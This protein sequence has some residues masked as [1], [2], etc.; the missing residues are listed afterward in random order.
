MTSVNIVKDRIAKLEVGEP[1]RVGGLSLVPI[2]GS[3]PAP[4]YFTASE[5]LSHG[6]LDIEELGDGTVPEILAVNNAV[7]PVLLLDG[8]HLE[9]AKQ[10]RIVN[11]SILLAANSTTR[12]PVSCV[13]QGRWAYR[14]GRKFASSDHH[15]YS[16]LRRIQA[17]SSLRHRK[18]GMAPRSDQGEVW[19]DVAFKHSEAAVGFS[20]AGAMRDAFDRQGSLLRKIEERMPRPAAGQVGILSCIGGRPVAADVFDQPATL[21]KLW[22]RL[23]RGYAMDAV[24]GAHEG[25][26]EV[27]LKAFLADAASAKAVSHQG[28]GIGEDIVLEKSG[29][30]GN[31]LVWSDHVLH[32]S[33]FRR[34]G[35]DAGPV[36]RRAENR[37]RPI[38]PQRRYF[39][40]S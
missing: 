5:A 24:G 36:D 30:L 15:S 21:A 13:E 40:T 27:D 29:V 7:L 35:G 4:D 37:E 9:G 28:V 23:I 33:L 8:E 26:E 31:G 11:L 1:N 20:E 32:I 6:F 14:G 34:E 10:S 17:E 38:R 19:A 18:A 22:Q 39:H 3:D 16:R 2:F 12:L 25:V